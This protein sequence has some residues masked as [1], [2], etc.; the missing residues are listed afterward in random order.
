MATTAGSTSAARS[1]ALSFC[2]ASASVADCQNAAMLR[3]TSRVPPRSSHAFQRI[4][5]QLAIDIASSSAATERLTPSPW[6]S[7]SRTLIGWP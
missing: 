5:T 1:K 3:S 6:V 7:S 2:S 4:T